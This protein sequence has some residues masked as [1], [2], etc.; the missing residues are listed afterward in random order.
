MEQS[1][2]RIYKVM[3]DADLFADHG[4]PGSE[5]MTV[6]LDQLCHLLLK[7]QQHVF[8]LNDDLLDGMLP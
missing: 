8:S 5:Q 2:C 4:F 6:F 3:F 1:A 7:K